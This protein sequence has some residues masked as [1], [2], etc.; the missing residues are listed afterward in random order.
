M[1]RTRS[2]VKRLVRYC[3]AQAESELREDEQAAIGELQAPERRQPGA[4]LVEIAYIVISSWRVLNRSNDDMKI[5]RIS[6]E[7]IR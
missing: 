2:G 4:R 1:S 3:L 5:S 6:G 7:L